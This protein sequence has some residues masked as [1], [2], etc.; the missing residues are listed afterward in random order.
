MTDD[1]QI[2]EAKPLFKD[3]FAPKPQNAMNPMETAVRG[4]NPKPDGVVNPLTL[5][6]EPRP[7]AFGYNERPDGVENPISEATPPPQQNSESTDEGEK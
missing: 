2:E 1:K 7:W 3:G 6:S 5:D 4:I